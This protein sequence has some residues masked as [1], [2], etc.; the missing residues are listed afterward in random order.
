MAQGFFAPD[1]ALGLGILTQVP[2]Y[3][4]WGIESPLITTI[5]NRRVASNDR[6]TVL[7]IN[8]FFTTLVIAIAEPGVG[9]VATSYGVGTG[10]AAGAIAAALPTALVL[11]RYRRSER[12]S[13]APAVGTNVARDR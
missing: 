11:A 8:S 7:A 2:D 4:F 3:V 13:P 10:L 5:I 9:Q 1:V 12:T 6:A